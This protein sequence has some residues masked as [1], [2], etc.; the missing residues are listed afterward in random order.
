VVDK[1]WI[2]EK[3][4]CINKENTTDKPTRETGINAETNPIQYSIRQFI[5]SDQFFDIRY[6]KNRGLDFPSGPI[7]GY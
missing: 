3:Q 7:P 1:K 5:G 4:Y 6:Q 2:K